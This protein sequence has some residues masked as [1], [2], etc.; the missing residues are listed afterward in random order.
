MLHVLHIR[1]LALIEH[2]ELQLGAGLNVV[3]GETG[4]G[5]SLLITALKILRGEKVSAG[6]VRHGAD[7]LQVD[8]EFRLGG[9]DRSKAVARLVDELCGGALDDDL[10][11]VTRY[12]D[13][14]GRSRVRIGGRPAT[15]TA[16]RELGQFLLEIHGQGDSR[17]LMRPEIQCETLDAFAGTAALRHE[18]AAA[19][20]TAR[21]ARQRLQQ[22]VEGAREQQQRLEFLRFQHAAM[23]EL[24]LQDGELASLAAEQQV[25]AN[26]ETLRQH[27]GTAVIHLQDGDANAADLLGRA[28]EALQD[29]AAIDPRLEAA[30]EQL[31]QAEDLLADACRK[32]QSG[33][34]RLELDPSRLAAVQERLDEIHAVLQRFGPTEQELRQNLLR[35]A[36]ELEQAEVLAADPAV[37]AAELQQATEAAASVGRKLL[38]A[39]RK[40]ALPFATQIV[41]ELQDLGMARTEVRV[42][43]ADAFAPEQL[44]DT[45]SAHGPVPVDIEVRI[46]P[47]EPFHSLRD[48][49]SGGELA[50]IVLAIKKTLADQDRV[51]LLVLDEI[52][53]EIGG[54]LGLQVGRKL[55]EVALHHQVVIVTHLAPVAAFAQRHFLVNKEVRGGAG[56]ERTA[57]AVRAL[58]GNDIERELAA[59]AMGDPGDAAALQQARRLVERARAKDDSPGGVAAED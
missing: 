46:N 2:A 30:S 58:V 5:K 31:A 20:A 28:R 56:D 22:R 47:G 41:A 39:R 53:A 17:A 14:Q 9:G 43:M 21:A 50:R 10:L 38:R 19:L 4:G 40:A 29:A 23:A 1:N 8:G 44:L 7:E 37:L 11:L 51:P 32:V 25:L 35:V 45:A 24:R 16:L 57:S 54:R 36:A 42:A 52:D 55:H 33:L 18:F 26:L 6:L 15:L 59:M 12:V 49:A 48:T 27:L 34:A 13:R 3:S